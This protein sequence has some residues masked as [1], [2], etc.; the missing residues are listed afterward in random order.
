MS[1]FKQ[2]MTLIQESD[3]PTL[4]SYDNFTNLK[5]TNTMNDDNF[6]KKLN[7]AINKLNKTHNSTKLTSIY[8]LIQNGLKSINQAKDK[9]NKEKAIASFKNQI[10]KEKENRKSGVSEGEKTINEFIFQ[11]LLKTEEYLAQ[12]IK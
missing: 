6:L 2:Y 12:K 5:I 4:P 11:F 1:R 3:D 9:E 10:A 7:E 8:D